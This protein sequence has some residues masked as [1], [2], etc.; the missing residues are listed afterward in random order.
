MIYFVIFFR[1][2]KFAETLQWC[3]DLGIQELTFYAFSIEN[4]K[5]KQEEVNGLLNLAQ[6]KFDSLV[7]EKYVQTYSHI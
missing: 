4:F 3:K 5:R 6:Q 2:D 1:F 7:G